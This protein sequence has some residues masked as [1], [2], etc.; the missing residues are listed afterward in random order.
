MNMYKTTTYLKH[1]KCATKE[2]SASQK[3][4]NVTNSPVAA[5]PDRLSTPDPPPKV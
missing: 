1:K 2:H 5:Q 4:Q 3:R